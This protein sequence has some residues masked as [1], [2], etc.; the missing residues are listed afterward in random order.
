MQKLFRSEFTDK[1]I[2]AVAHRLDTV[3]DF[4]RIILMDQGI[5]VENGSPQ[6]LL[7]TKSKFR[8][9]WDSSHAEA[10]GKSKIEQVQ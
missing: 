9:L 8:A 10:E 5:M 4:D 3:V 6:E 1:T 2:V 7:A